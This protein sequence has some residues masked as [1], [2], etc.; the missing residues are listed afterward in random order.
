MALS[1][2]GLSNLI[3]SELKASSSVSVVD[4]ASFKDWADRMAAA[5]VNHITANAVVSV[6]VTGGSSAGTYTGTVS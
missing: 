2:S 4:D 5:I 6:T 3:Q 1:E